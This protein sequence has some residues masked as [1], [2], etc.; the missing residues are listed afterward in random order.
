[1]SKGNACRGSSIVT[2][3]YSKADIEKVLFELGYRIVKESSDWTFY[4]LVE[5]FE[6]QDDL[7]LDWSMKTIEWVDFERQLIYREIDS[8][9]IH[10]SL[11]HCHK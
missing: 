9:S 6:V 3:R 5:D 8:K 4:E 10:E 7:L 2:E 1:M 11:L